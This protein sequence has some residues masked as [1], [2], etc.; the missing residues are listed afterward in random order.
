MMNCKCNFR[1][2][3]STICTILCYKCDFVISQ[4]KIASSGAKL[5]SVPQLIMGA[6]DFTL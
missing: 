6:G 2:G 3:D 4:L 5:Q 1:I